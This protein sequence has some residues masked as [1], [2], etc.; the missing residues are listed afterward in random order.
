MKRLFSWPISRYLTITAILLTT[1]VNAQ[2]KINP[3]SITIVRDQWGVPHI[4]G[5]TDPEVAYGLAWANAEDNFEMMQH[6]LLQG[7]SRFGMAKGK[8]GAIRDFFCQALRI[9]EIVESRYETDITPEFKAYL[10]GYADGV[11]AY[12]KAHPDEVIYK[13]GFP[14]TPKDIL[15]GVTFT[16]CLISFV[17]NPVQDIIKGKFDKLVL[18]Y[19]NPTCPMGSNGIAF[20]SAK[21]VDGYPYLACNPHQPF[22]GQ[23]SFYEAHL[24]SKQGLNVLGA[25]FPGGSS[26]F[27][28]SNNYLGWTHTYN[29]LDLVDTYKLKMHPKKKRQYEFDGEWRK[30]EKKTAWMK[31]KLKKWLTVYV[32]KKTYWSVYGATFQSSEDKKQFYSIRTLAN[33]NIVATQQWYYMDKATNFTQF[34]EALKP[35]G[36][37]RFNIV[38]ADRYDT[39]LYLSNG[40]IP[41]RCDDVDWK[42]VIPGTSSKTLWKSQYSLTEL[43]QIISPKCGYVYNT[44]NSEFSA[45]CDSE[46]LDSTKYSRTMGLWYGNNNR[47]ARAYELINK[48]DKFTYEEFKVLRSDQ[49]FPA[50]TNFAKSTIGKIVTLDTTKFPDLAGVIKH[51]R[52]WNYNTAATNRQFTI[53]GPAIRHLFRKKGFGARELETGINV[54]DTVFAESLRFIKKKL[55][56]KFG[57]FDVAWGDYQ[58]HQLGKVDLPVGGSLDVLAAMHSDNLPDGRE[59]AVGGDTYIQMVRFTPQGALIESVVPYGAS[60]RPDSK[61]YTDQM[62]M[63]VNQ[64]L[65]PM[66]LDRDTIFKQAERIYNPK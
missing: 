48:Q 65:K 41:K 34:Y 27:I 20:S 5:N 21:T 49:S 24:C 6:N 14:T 50:H 46:N 58:R 17:Q 25:M 53:I 16:N 47:A 35:I 37:V 62:E 39:I 3:D 9:S 52:N 36:I 22:E 1:L 33:Q 30:L 63:Y 18:D 12:A 54:S 23:H 43:P 15:K 51:V 60:A 26:I 2:T 40:A 59:R 11:N 56:D 61:H 44:N 64:K 31:V 55:E 38:Y 13:K 8:E 7:I 42:G 28:G 29:G 57:T 32:P 45:T 66:S 10:Q 19:N 4:F